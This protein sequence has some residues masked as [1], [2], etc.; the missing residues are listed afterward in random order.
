M[1]QRIL[2]TA[3]RG[4]FALSL[5]SPSH[6]TREWGN[7]FSRSWSKSHL[8]VEPGTNTLF[9]GLIFVHLGSLMWESLRTS[10]GPDHSPQD[11]SAGLFWAISN[12]TDE[13]IVN[14]RRV[15]F[16]A[17]ADFLS[18]RSGLCGMEIALMDEK[19]A[20][21]RWGEKCR[22]DWGS[23]PIN[24]RSL[25]WLA[26]WRGHYPEELWRSPLGLSTAGPMTRPLWFSIWRIKRHA[27]PSPPG[28]LLNALPASLNPVD[29]R[30]SEPDHPSHELTEH[31]VWKV[32]QRPSWHAGDIKPV[33]H[34]TFDPLTNGSSR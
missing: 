1:A 22:H 12:L 33:R 16:K 29:T 32:F 13:Q 25:K 19:R 24:W 6:I 11:G 5:P 8:P 28:C 10:L 21:V 15:Y 9:W 31:C 20:R 30:V 23:C 2:E 14:T 27:G 4:M 3:K 18:R 26:S 17:R 34:F 7:H